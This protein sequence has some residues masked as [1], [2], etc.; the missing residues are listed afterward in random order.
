MNK[1]L[2][3]SLAAAAVLVATNA[4]AE[5][6]FYENDDFQGRSFTANLQISNF[7][8]YGFNDRASS[9][10]VMRDR[11]EVCEDAQFEG[12]CIVLRPGRYPSLSS[13]GL[14]DRI[15][16]VRNIGTNTRIDYDR[17]APPSYPV[18]DNRRR[19]N[20]RMYE[21]DVTSVRAVLGTPD[22]RCWV[23]R[24]RVTDYQSNNNVSGAI[25][26]AIIGGVLG[27]QVGGGRGKD[28]ATA[29]GAVTG[30][31]V[32]NN[33]GGDGGDKRS[34]S[35][36]VRRCEIDSYGDGGRPEYW[37]VTYVYRGQEHRVQMTYPPGSTITVNRQGEPR[38]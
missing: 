7:Q 4:A 20:E 15:S 35:Q 14:N 38:S 37:D 26:G 12:R 23:E 32:G 2:R 16:S 24:E 5:V 13:M 34:Y 36:N 33:T 18:Y 6:I 19:G 21:A 29:L 22:R 25:V 30:A 17:Y 8:Q 3:L 11:W 28:V 9:V 1:N 31:A 27:H 10:V